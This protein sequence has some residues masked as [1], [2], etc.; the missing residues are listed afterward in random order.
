LTLSFVSWLIKGLSRSA[1]EAVE[2]ETPANRARSFIVFTFLVE[3]VMRLPDGWL[4]TK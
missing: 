2:D 4:P 3:L 1:R